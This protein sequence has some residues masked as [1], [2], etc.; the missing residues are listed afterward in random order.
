MYQINNKFEIGEECYTVRREATDY[1]CPFCEGRGDKEYDGYIIKCKSCMGTGKLKHPSET[2]LVVHK[3]RIR[4]IIVAIW[5][6]AMSIKYKVE[7]VGKDFANIR[8]RN[9][10]TLF[11]TLEEAEAYCEGVNTE[12]ITPEF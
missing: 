4:R 3:V 11:K 1:K 2:V 5:K 6:D 12:Q 10:T 8:N 7:T 9:E